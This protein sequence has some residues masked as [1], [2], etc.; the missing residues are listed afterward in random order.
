MSAQKRQYADSHHFRSRETAK[1]KSRTTYSTPGTLNLAIMTGAICGLC[2]CLWCSSHAQSCL[3]A[4][5]AS[6]VFALLG[7]TCYVLM[8]EAD[9]KNF[10]DN[11]LINENA[12]RILA[13]F[14]QPLFYFSVRSTWF[15]IKT[16]AASMSV[17]TIMR[18]MKI[19]FSNLRNGILY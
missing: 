15:I 9:H 12:G 18:Q 14:F 16:I 10:H 8:H 6:V 3:L 5:V 1:M 2:L 4:I 11:S 7:N 13:G 17:S 19:V